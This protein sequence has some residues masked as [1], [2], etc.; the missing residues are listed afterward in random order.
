MDE[1]NYPTWK[2]GVKFLQVSTDEVYGSL[3]NDGFLQKKLPLIYV[4]H[5]VHLKQGVIL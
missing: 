4:L 1:N 2:E 5:I 3:G